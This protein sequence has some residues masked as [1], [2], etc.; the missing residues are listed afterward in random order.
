MNGR[1]VQQRR[2]QVAIREISG[3]SLHRQSS[4]QLWLLHSGF[5][6]TIHSM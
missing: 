5:K 1:T 6:S 3:L 4:P 2:S